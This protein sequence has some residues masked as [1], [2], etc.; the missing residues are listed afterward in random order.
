M[1]RPYSHSKVRWTSSVSKHDAVAPVDYRSC[2]VMDLQIATERGPPI[3]YMEIPGAS[4]YIQPW[5]LFVLLLAVEQEN[6]GC[7]SAHRFTRC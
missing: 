5:A 2:A 6:V 3:L 7:C 1:I 4:S